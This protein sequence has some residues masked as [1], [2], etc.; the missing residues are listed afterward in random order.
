[1]S[2]RFRLLFLLIFSLI[3]LFSFAQAQPVLIAVELTNQEQIRLW[4]NLDYPTYELIHNTAIAEVGTDE[5]PILQDKG[6]QCQI[7]DDQPWTANYY[8]FDIP[9]DIGLSLPF[10]PIWHKNQSYL[11][12]IVADEKKKLFDLPLKFCQL[13]RTELPNRF[14]DRLTTNLVPLQLINWDPFIQNLV[15]QVNTD[16]IFSYVQ[17]LQNF[18]TRLSFT[19]SSFAAS[20]WLDKNSLAGDIMHNSIVIMSI[21]QV[22]VIGLIPVTSETW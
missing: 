11:V 3:G 5:T 18:K 12:K 7:I 1:M 10:T 13:K 21:K 17:R 9:K 20:E 4:R 14:W 6:F 19:D 2:F 22:G 8:L 15:D 16:S